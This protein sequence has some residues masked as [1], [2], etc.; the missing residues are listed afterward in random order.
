M[1][2]LHGTAPD[3]VFG[4]AHPPVADP[5]GGLKEARA[6]LAANLVD[7]QRRQRGPPS[8]LLFLRNAVE[9]VPH[10]PAIGHEPRI[11]DQLTTHR[12]F[13]EPGVDV[14]SVRVPAARRHERPLHHWSS[15]VWEV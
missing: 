3:L 1:H 9:L 6:R 8:R 14:R 11:G 2:F 12:G 10:L 13:D 7:D 15:A 4:L 5:L